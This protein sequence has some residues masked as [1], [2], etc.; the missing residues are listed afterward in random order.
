MPYLLVVSGP[1]MHRLSLVFILHKSQQQ[2]FREPKSVPKSAYP[3]RPNP[4]QSQ[5]DAQPA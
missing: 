1:E 4:Y 3:R 5:A 2:A